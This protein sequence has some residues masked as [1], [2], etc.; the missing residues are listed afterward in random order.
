MV[1]FK[2]FTFKIGGFKSFIIGEDKNAYA[3]WA[4]AYKSKSLTKEELSAKITEHVNK[5]R[6]SNG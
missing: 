5:K 1:C 4:L 2:R 3:L 6:S